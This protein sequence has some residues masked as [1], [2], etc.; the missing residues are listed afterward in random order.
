MQPETTLTN[1]F[2]R[3]T[4]LI[5]KSVNLSTSLAR[6]QAAGKIPSI[7]S[8]ASL[9]RGTITQGGGT[10]RYILALNFIEL[11]MD[12]KNHEQFIGTARLNSSSSLF[13]K[14]KFLGSAHQTKFY[15]QKAGNL[16]NPSR[17]RH[18]LGM[19]LFELNKTMLLKIDLSNQA[20]IEEAFSKPLE[21]QLWNKVPAKDMYRQADEEN[22]LGSFFIELNELPRAHNVR[23]KNQ[24]MEK[25]NC[26]EGYFVMHDFK[27]E[28][29]S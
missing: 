9:N 19:A 21:L 11:I 14:T 23:T 3:D 24:K 10:S 29:V 6:T 12:C 1:E 28:R 20:E 2:K 7:L 27:K 15:A 5:D 22:L 25:F 18:Q 16:N 8:S 4:T 26:H 17:F 13:F